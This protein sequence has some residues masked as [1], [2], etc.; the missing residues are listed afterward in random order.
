MGKKYSLHLTGKSSIISLVLAMMMICG[1]ASTGKVRQQTSEEKGAV[2]QSVDVQPSPLKTIVK[3]AGSSTP[4]YTTFQLVNPPRIIVDIRGLRDQGLP[5]RIDVGAGN[6]DSI[7]IEKGDT[8]NMTTRVMLNLTGDVDYEASSQDNLVQLTLT[9]KTPPVE[10]GEARAQTVVAAEPEASPSAQ[11]RIFVKPGKAKVNQVLGIDFLMLEQGKSRVVVTTD[12]KPEYDMDQ[13][14]PKNPVLKLSKATIK[15]QLLREIDSSHFHGAVDRIKPSFSSSGQEVAISIALRELVPFHVKQEDTE[16]S[17]DFEPTSIPP[18]EKKIVPLQLAQSGEAAAESPEET[19]P[20][21]LVEEEKAAPI[22]G[23]L[24][25]EYTGAPMTMDFVNADVTNILRL[26]GEV[27]NLNIVW[28]PEVQGNVSMRLK[29]VPWDQALDLILANNEL[30]KREA[31][32]VIWITTKGKMTQIEAEEKSKRDAYEAELEAKR[33]KIQE[34]REKKKELE[35]IVT[36]YIGVDFASADEMKT[37]IEGILTERGSISVDNRTS[38]LIVKD[39]AS[40]VEEARTLVKQFDT[41]VKQVMIEARIVDATT[42]FT[43]DLGIRW[44][45][46]QIQNRSNTNVPFTNWGG[47][48]STVETAD[49]NPDDA[50]NP[51]PAGGALYSPTLTTNAPTGWSPNLGIVFSKLNT[52]GLTSTILDA[53]LALSEAEGKSK[54]I[55]APKVIAMNGEE[56]V[57]SRGDSIVLESTENVESIT[58]DATLSLTVTPVVS[59]NNYITLTVKVTD[60]KAPTNRLLLKKTVETKLMVKSSETIVIGGIYTEEEGEDESGIPGL[61]RIPL[62]GW[63]FKAK[64]NTSTKT[65]LLIFLTPTVVPSSI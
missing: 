5:E 29:N 13:K 22:P 65:E 54:T 34:E 56:A 28:G 51:W 62:L 55:S 44:D 48:P 42:N 33:K 50:D 26:I 11:P 49:P 25:K 6:I 45:K 38:T 47:T 1:C 10:T 14:D 35:P 24:K 46:F 41:P 36:E 18:V 31:G 30:A 39:I 32:N 15:P 9:P 52:F 4:R 3:I 8:Q 23:L 7:L 12:K 60:D 53:K 27:S 43:R 17:I 59:Y 61:R 19:V 37:H 20:V 2:I 40:S 21:G 63:L 57:I 16:I 64:R 58:L